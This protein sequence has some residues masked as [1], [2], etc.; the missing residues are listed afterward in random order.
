MTFS[1]SFMTILH[2]SE[3]GVSEAHKPK[4]STS[5]NLEQLTMHLSI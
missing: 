5:V 1:A 2:L 4:G 3:V